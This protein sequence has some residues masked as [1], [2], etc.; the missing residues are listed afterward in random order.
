LP[1]KKFLDFTGVLFIFGYLKGRFIGNKPWKS[2]IQTT[3]IGS[4]ASAVSFFL[5]RLLG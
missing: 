4:I 5:A 3:V 2:A 1:C